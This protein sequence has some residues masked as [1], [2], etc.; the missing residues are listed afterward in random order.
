MRVNSI[1]IKL[2]R[3]I[4]FILIFGISICLLSIYYYCTTAANSFGLDQY[5][6]IE[7]SKGILEGN[8]KLVGMR[9]SRL[10]W[11]FPMI[12]YLLVPL[13]AVTS[14]PLTFFFSTAVTYVFGIWSISWILYKNRTVSELLVFIGLSITHV[15]SLFYSSFLWQQ[16]YIPFFVSMFFIC[17]FYYLKNSVNTWLFHGAAVFLN[18]AFQLH[19]MSAVLILGFVSA[20]IFLGKL[21]RYKHWFLQFG[22]QLMLVSPWIIYHVFFID[23]ASEPKY[24]SSLFKDFFSPAKAFFNYL[25]GSGLT[26]EYTLYL[27]YGTNTF[28]YETFWFNW[29]SVGGVIF[30]LILFWTLKHLY[31]L[32][33]FYAFSMK[34]I[35]LYLSPYYHEERDFNRSY[36][37]A[38]YCLFMPTLLYLLSGI[39]MFPHYFQFLTPLLFLLIAVLPGQ[40]EG[41]T[42]RKIA[43]YGIIMYV[44]NQGSFSYWR[45]WEEYK[46][47][48][49]DDIGYTK[50][51]AQSV[52]ENCRDYPQ[53]RFASKLGLKNTD[54]MFHYLFEPQLK[55]LKKTGTLFCRSILVFQNKLLL[56]SPI[57]NWYLQQLE[58][59]KKLEVHNNQIWIAGKK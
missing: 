7:Y 51:L 18:I 38:L 20:L 58:P 1:K 40:L 25:S 37:I 52:A 50:V 59:L 55:V 22:I 54:E 42:L 4:S 36:P 19:T 11:N 43:Y 26:R 10:N 44:I 28:P 49:L 32:Q 5:K 41:K 2:S 21:P 15:Y 27:G 9:T 31:S 14:N 13:A 35:Y 12:H 46:A 34:K 17:F 47:P 53:I 48:Y 29:L 24:H 8:F 33:K 16:N 3:T 45:S 23:W 39:V 6:I 30:L 57:V 56:Q